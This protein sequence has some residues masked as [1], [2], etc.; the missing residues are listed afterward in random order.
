V[1][2]SPKR[3]AMAYERWPWL[4]NCIRDRRY[5]AEVRTKTRCLPL[6]EERSWNVC[7]PRMTYSARSIWRVARIDAALTRNSKVDRILRVDPGES[8]EPREMWKNLDG[9]KGTGTYQSCYYKQSSGTRMSSS[10]FL[11][12]RGAH[13][14]F[15]TELK[16][17][18]G[19]T[20]Q[21]PRP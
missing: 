3:Y 21:A 20:L 5:T 16:G 8:E 11:C 10:I 14:S 7:P 4:R 13:S 15:R 2:R 18:R 17:I 1:R 6:P 12:A 19:P 9:R